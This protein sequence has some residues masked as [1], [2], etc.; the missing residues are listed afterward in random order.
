MFMTAIAS[1]KNAETSVP[2]MPPTWWKESNSCLK[3]SAL[4][5]T[6]TEASTTMVE[7]PREK[8]NPTVTGR[9]PSCISLQVTLSMAAMWSAS[10]A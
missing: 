1:R 7:W 5:A 10:T 8:K 3:A 4:A 2:M 6:A 9:L